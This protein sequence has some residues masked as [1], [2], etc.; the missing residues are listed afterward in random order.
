MLA[1]FAGKVATDLGLIQFDYRDGTA[2]ILTQLGAMRKAVVENHSDSFDLLT[3]YLNDQSH[4]ALTITHVANPQQQVVDTSRLPRG[5]VH[6]RY[7]LFRANQGAPLHDGIIM[8]DRRHFKRWLAERGGDYR[9]VAQDM[10]SQNINVTP[11]SE[12]GYLGRGTNIK[13]GQQYVISINVNHP[14]LVGI[15]ANEDNRSLSAQLSVVQGG[16][17]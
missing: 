10:T 3:E 12:K 11:Q 2:H 13:L 16:K 5:E 17:P 8:I 9:N 15:L 7:D 6:I 1:D 4:T 14:R